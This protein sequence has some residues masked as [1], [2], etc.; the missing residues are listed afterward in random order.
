MTFIVLCTFDASGREQLVGGTAP[1]SIAD[2]VAGEVG[3]TVAHLYLTSGSYDAVV[4][5]EA[6]RHHAALAFAVAF[7]HAAGAKTL[8]LSAEEA[9]EQLVEAARSAHTRVGL[10]PRHTR[11]G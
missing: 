8:T 9:S 10:A 11:I 4:I 3:A 5:L 7:G 1:R 2:T 6:E